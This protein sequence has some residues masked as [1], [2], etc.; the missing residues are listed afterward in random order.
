MKKSDDRV[1]KR[2]TAKP[3]KDKMPIPPATFDGVSVAHFLFV[4]DAIE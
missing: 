4:R 2:S 3:D 1:G